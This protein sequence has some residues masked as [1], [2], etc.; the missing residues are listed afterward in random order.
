MSLQSIINTLTRM[1]SRRALNWGINKGID[2]IAK[3]G[4]KP[5]KVSAK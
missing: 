5:A 3:S 2:R 4:G 1:V